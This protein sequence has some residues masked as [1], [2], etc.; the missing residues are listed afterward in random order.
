MSYHIFV[1]NEKGFNS[2]L[3]HNGLMFYLGGNLDD[4]VVFDDK[5]EV[6]SFINNVSSINT[7]SEEFDDYDTDVLN[8]SNAKI[9][10]EKIIGM[11]DWK[12]KPLRFVKLQRLFYWILLFH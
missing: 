2:L 1:A 9:R 5:N 3:C 7:N 8:M 12:E 4:A 10:I 11:S 6:D